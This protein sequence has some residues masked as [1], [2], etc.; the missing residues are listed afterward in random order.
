MQHVQKALLDYHHLLDYAGD[1]VLIP[2]AKF[3]R[4]ALAGYLQPL[5]GGL[6]PEDTST[7]AVMHFTEANCGVTFHPE[8]A[9][10][11][12]DSPTLFQHKSLSNHGLVKCSV[13]TNVG[14]VW[15]SHV[16]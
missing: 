4:L 7:P 8:V 2:T 14:R 11:S 15:I 3:P 12:T 13:T 5:L 9:S 6:T 16:G 1:L 10:I